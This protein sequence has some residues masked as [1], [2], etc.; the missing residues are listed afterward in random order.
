VFADTPNKVAA[1]NSR[2]NAFTLPESRGFASVTGPASVSFDVRPH[3]HIKIMIILTI[4][5]TE[6]EKQPVHVDGQFWHQCITKAEVE[7][8]REFEIEDFR[9]DMCRLGDAALRLIPEKDDGRD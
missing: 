6:N 7:T 4:R 3:I 1:P 8:L 9:V 5:F 2:V